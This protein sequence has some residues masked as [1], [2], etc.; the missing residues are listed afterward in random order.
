MN[1][2][3]SDY[4]TFNVHNSALI[5][6]QTGTGKTEFVRSMLRRY[7]KAYTPE[8][9]KY[10]IFDLKLVEFATHRPDGSIDEDGAKEEYL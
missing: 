3:N 9:M 10:V 1:I 5:V 6:G 4:F 7:E 2:T 8:Q